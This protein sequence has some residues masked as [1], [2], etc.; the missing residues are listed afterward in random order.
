MSSVVPYDADMDEELEDD[1]LEAWEAFVFAHAAVHSRIERALFEAGTISLTWYDVL[2][3]LSNA[4]D[5]RLRMGELAES[6]ILS[7]SGLSRLVDRIEQAGLL[8]RERSADD[9]RGSEA[10]LTEAGAIAVEEAWPHY[11]R[12]IATYFADNL[13]R[14][15]IRTLARALAKVRDQFE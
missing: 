10:V 13:S 5:Q 9:R 7:R 11:A 6:L 1:V 4:P 3:A 2:V 8:V 14:G 12:S 15:E